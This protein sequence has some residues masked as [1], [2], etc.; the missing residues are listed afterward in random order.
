VWAQAEAGVHAG[1]FTA[2]LQPQD[3]AFIMLHSAGGAVDGGGRK[4]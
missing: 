2:T 4:V 1:A 3:S